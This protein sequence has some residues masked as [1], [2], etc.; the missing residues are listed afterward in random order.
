MTAEEFKEESNE[1]YVDE[2][3]SAGEDFHEL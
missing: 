1:F 2:C 3:V